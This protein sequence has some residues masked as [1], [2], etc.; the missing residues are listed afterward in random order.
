LKSSTLLRGVA[1]LFACALFALVFVA[2]A[3][4]AQDQ[5]MLDP[6]QPSLDEDPLF[7]VD[8]PIGAIEYR[9]GRGLHFGRT[10]LNIGG[11]TT[12]EFERE[13][14]GPGELALDGLNFLVLLQPIDWAR[15]FAEIEI[16][17]LL[18]WQTDQSSVESDPEAVIER[19]FGDL[20]LSDPLT[21]RFGKFQTPVGRW[22]LVPAE[23]FTWSA[24]EPVVVETAF[25]EH[26]T[27]AA[28]LG[29]LYPDSGTLDYWIYGQVLDPLHPSESPDPLDRS[30]GARLQ[31]DRSVGQWSVGASFLASELGPDWSY[32]GG[33]DAEWL[34]GPLE[35]TGEFT[36]Q[37]G[38]IEDRDL[39]D[40]YVQG[41]Y[42]VLLGCLPNVYL[43]GRYEHF[44]PSEPD[45]DANLWDLG[46]TWIPRPYLRLKATYRLSDRETNDVARGV[47]VTF[48]VVF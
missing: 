47:K 9:A 37:R 3:A 1:T 34:I 10:G 38:N 28:L 39:W 21:A 15:A 18:T 32:L 45:N 43:V 46:V 2:R 16:D 40:V 33:L 42:E 27:G 24:T 11:F 48:S 29:S 12:L 14:G 44:H 22:N 26:T 35:L 31:F 6:V 19:L 5:Q 17:N 23:P 30:V 4:S 7:S 36:I 13:E 8:S 41:V 25:D 20:I